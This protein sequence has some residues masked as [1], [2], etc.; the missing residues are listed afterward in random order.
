MVPHTL[1]VDVSNVF[2]LNRP[3]QMFFLPV[4]CSRFGIEYCF[5]WQFDSWQYLDHSAMSLFLSLL[6]WFTNNLLSARLLWKH[7]A[8]KKMLN[9]KK[10]LRKVCVFTVL[11]L[12][13]R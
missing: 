7:Q 3:K 6:G 5:C 8:Q 12:G 13:R 4:C 10:Y 2:I 9:R 1:V 11:Q